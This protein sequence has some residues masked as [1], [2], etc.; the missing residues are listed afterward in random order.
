MS[1]RRR[2]FLP[3]V[4]GPDLLQGECNGK[5]GEKNHLNLKESD[6]NYI[7]LLKALRDYDV[8]GLV[9]CESPN[10]EEDAVLLQQTYLELVKSG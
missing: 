9:I 5:K 7:D 2:S 10:L 3:A 8:K 6:L 1:L 4:V